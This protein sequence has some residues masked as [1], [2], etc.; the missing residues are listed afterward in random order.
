MDH[1]ARII[2]T[3]AEPH[4]YIT[5]ITDETD[6]V[7]LLTRFSGD[8]PLTQKAAL[9]LSL[10]LGRAALRIAFRLSKW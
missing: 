1:Q 8:V 9:H 5:V 2:P 10:A 4:D 3:K 6:N 7:T